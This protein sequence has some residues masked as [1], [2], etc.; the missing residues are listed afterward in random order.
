MDW[1]ISNPLFAWLLPAAGLPVL[2]HLFFKLKKRP[3]VFPT[4]MFFDQI[5]PQLSARRQIRH[6]LVLLLRTLFLLFLL[7][8]LARPVWLIGGGTGSVAVVCIIDNSG[9]M[10]GP[11]VGDRSKL[12]SAVEAAR[13]LVTNLTGKDTAAVLELVEDPTVVLPPGLESDKAAIKSAL[14]RIV[15]TEATGEPAAVFQRAGALL[16]ASAA[17]RFEIHIF[18]DL[19]ETE[20][21]RAGTGLKSPRAG[22]TIVFHRFASPAAKQPNLSLTAIAISPHRRLAGRPISLEITVA[23]PGEVDAVARLNWADD[24]DNKGTVEIALPRQSE[25]NLP[26]IVKPVSAGFHWVQVWLEG[27]SFTADNKAGIGFVC[28]EKS[29]VLFAGQTNDFGLLPLAIAPAASGLAAAFGSADKP[30][31]TVTTWE[32][33]ANFQNLVEQGG[34]LLVVPALTATGA[35]RPPAWLGATCDAVATQPSGAPVMIFRANAAIFTDLRD[36]DGQVTLRGVKA[37]K[38]QPLRPANEQDAVF[39]LDDGRAL[40]T[41]HRVGKGVVFA[42]GLAFDPSWTTLPLKGAFLAIAQG[43]ALAYTAGSDNTSAIVAGERLPGTGTEPAEI[44]S[45]A[46]SPLDWRGESG[47]LPVLPRAGIYTVKTGPTTRYIAVRSSDKEGRPRFLTGN[48]V[49]LLA[50]VPHTVRNF[51]DLTTFLRQARHIS[52]GLDLFLP[53]LLLAILMV[54]LE[55]WF[56]NPARRTR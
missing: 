24:A 44:K 23:N 50:G 6:W 43:M 22:T 38:Y 9:S 21:N 16:E 2:F 30:V 32:R 47:H 39:G 31:L 3:R 19:Q 36:A 41:E 25:K 17:T 34:N 55:T 13:A 7:L 52:R 28:T 5:D 29:T 35:V 26:V 33:V 20:W 1:R 4:L 42:S 15:D 18:T 53:L 27:D 40:L 37:F 51:T 54:L 48:Q 8:A 56:A 12:H 10:S 46:G 45:L 49:P 14:D 11:A